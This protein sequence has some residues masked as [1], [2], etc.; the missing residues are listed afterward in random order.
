MNEEERRGHDEARV[1]RAS[2]IEGLLKWIKERVGWR[3]NQEE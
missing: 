2:R 3:R 1:G